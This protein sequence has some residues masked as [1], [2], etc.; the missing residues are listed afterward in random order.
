MIL[1]SLR[2]LTV[3]ALLVAGALS[4]T[5]CATD[6][7]PDAE[8]SGGP[9]EVLASF[10]PLQYVTE[11]VGGDLVTVSSLTPPGAEPHDLELSPRQVRE[12]GDADVVVYL[13]GLQAAVDE[14]VTAR[15]PAHVVDAAGTAAVAEHL[16]GAE[17]DE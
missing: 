8:G 5:A 7:S 9:L 2:R 16:E 10:Y 4:L 11:Q 15:A 14:A 17:H 6:A 13:S 12:V 3:P 1:M